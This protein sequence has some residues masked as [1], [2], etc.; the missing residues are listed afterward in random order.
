M[1]RQNI[2]NIA[3]LNLH[4]REKRN[5]LGMPVVMLHPAPQCSSSLEPLMETLRSDFRVVAPDMPGFGLSEALRSSYCG[6]DEYLSLYKE[7][8]DRLIGSRFMLYGRGTSA[9]FALAFANAYPEKIT[10]LFLDDLF[11]FEDEERSRMV[12]NCVVDLSPK[13]GGGHLAEA[14]RVSEGFLRFFPWFEHDNVHEYRE[15]EPTAEEINAVLQC[16]LRSGT[17][18]LNFCRIAFGHARVENLIAST[19]PATVFRRAGSYFARYADRIPAGKLP[20]DVS[21]TDLA[22]DPEESQEQILAAMRW[23]HACQMSNCVPV[24]M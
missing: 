15:S 5:F 11:F 17:Q 13:Q 3:G 6:I 22:M 7:I 24:P 2:R 9:Q 18:L 12:S 16:F 10:H 19:V 1:I 14:W 8:T 20:P 21:I 4:Y 23:A